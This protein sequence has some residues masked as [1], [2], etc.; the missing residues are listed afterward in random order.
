MR[1]LLRLMTVL[2][3]AGS[4]DQFGKFLSRNFVRVN[5]L[6]KPYMQPEIV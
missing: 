1:Y 6:T 4:L 3:L 2:H 5:P